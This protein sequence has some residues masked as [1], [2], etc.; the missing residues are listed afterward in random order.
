MARRC[1][2]SF[3]G[4]TYSA[5]WGYSTPAPTPTPTPAPAPAPAPAP[6]TPSLT[7][8]VTDIATSAPISG[9]SVVV[10]YIT[11]YTTTDSAGR[12]QFHR[13]LAIG[14]HLDFGRELR[15]QFRSI[16]SA[17]QD[18]YMYRVERI[19]AGLDDHHR[20]AG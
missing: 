7:G 18:F 16:H 8:Q 11:Q 9:A 4:T 12:Y 20:H 5:D 14:P 17:T 3:H 15:K 10:S 6:T 13:L 1:V 2:R 19:T